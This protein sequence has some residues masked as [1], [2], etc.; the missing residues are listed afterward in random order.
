MTSAVAETSLAH[1]ALPTAHLSPRQRIIFWIVAVVCAATRFMAMA[2]TLWDWDEALFCL[3]M[4][5]YDVTN[6]HPHPPGFPVYIF[7]A[8]LMRLFTHDDFRALQ[9]INLIAGMLLFPAMFLL[10]RELRFRFTT[11]VIAAAMCA[12]FPNVWFFGGTAF[13]DVPS[14]VLVVFAIAMFFRGCRD[15]NAYLIATLLLALAIGIRP[16]NLIVGLFPGALATWYR[17]RANWR[18]VVFA[19]ILGLTI[20]ALAFGSAVIAT[21]SWPDYISAVRTHAS[22]ISRIDSFHSP[23]R[24]PLW[25]LFDRFFIKIYQWQLMNVIVSIFGA[26]SIIG[27]IRSRDRRVLYIVLAFL[28]V[29]IA[30]WLMLD[31]YSITRFSIGYCPMFAMLAADGIA[32]I[33][34]KRRDV[35]EPLL[36]ATV[37]GLFIGWTAPALTSVRN[38][39]APSVAAA[40]AVRQHIDPHRDQLYV[41]FS[42]TPFL[43]YFVPYF[44]HIRVEGERALPIAPPPRRPFLLTEIDVEKPAGWV[45]TRERGRLWNITRR[46][47]FDTALEPIRALP[48]FVSGWYVAERSGTEESRWMGRHS[49][50]NLPPRNGKSALHLTFD[51]PDELM[52]S[53]PRLTIS[54]NGAI[55]E[56]FQPAEAHMTREYEVEAASNGAMN[57][58]EL[59]TTQVLNEQKQ[60]LGTDPRDLGILLKWLSWGEP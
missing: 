8:K 51:I 34:W 58:L 24:P 54:L 9:S 36:G 59:D 6:H 43:E 23:E 40:L 29:A 17:W 46:H 14:I 37:I 7:A 47:Y 20:T 41:G 53:K 11:S 16:Q 1:F 12:F 44:P 15:A 26:I 48:Q 3:G 2:R 38:D 13:S 30:A 19:A 50:T 55:I 4:R 22:Y 52:T 39:V 57:V 42:M 45:F 25:R 27:A 32:R 21:G 31:R 18:D 33:S 5:A 10:A 56:R 35:F 60:R 49:V 28:P